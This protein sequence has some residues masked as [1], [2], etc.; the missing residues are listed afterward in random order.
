[1]VLLAAVDALLYTYSGEEDLIVSSIFAARKHRSTSKPSIP[2][3]ITSR[4]T[5]G[6]RLAW[7]GG[8]VDSI[9]ANAEESDPWAN[10]RGD[11]YGRTVE[12]FWRFG[13]YSFDRD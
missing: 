8:L 6:L 7:D 13:H 1:M 12:K 3:S 11:A 4:T 2:G 9:C 5:R 10:P